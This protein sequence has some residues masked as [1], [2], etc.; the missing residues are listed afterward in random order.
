MEEWEVYIKIAGAVFGASGIWKVL[1]LLFK[2]KIE[3]KLNAAET[4]KLHVQAEGQ[5]VGN[6]IQWSQH[7]EQRV[8]ELESVAEENRELTKMVNS[9]RQMMESQKSRI[10]QLEAKVKK[11]Q[12]ENR[13]LRALI[14]KLK[15]NDNE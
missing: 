12:T 8:K 14:T 10:S 5:I 9:Q 7:L 13:S 1:E 4:M 6:W 11:L 3:R 2:A 15:A